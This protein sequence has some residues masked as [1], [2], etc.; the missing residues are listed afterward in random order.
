MMHQNQTT[1]KNFAFS[2]ETNH[3][4]PEILTDKAIDFLLNCIKI[5]QQ[6]NFIIRQEKQQALF[7]AGA[8]P[9]FPIETTNIR[10][11]Q[12]ACSSPKR[13]DRRVEITGPVDRKII[14][15]LNFGVKHSW[16][17]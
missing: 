10:E 16:L 14:N 8:L 15:A 13:L 4:Y 9:C 3:T 17:T 7:D 6:D 12:L 2:A 11:K 5:Q 1:E